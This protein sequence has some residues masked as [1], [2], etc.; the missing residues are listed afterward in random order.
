MSELAIVE[1][2]LGLSDSRRGAGKRHQQA[3]CDTAQAF[4][5]RIRSYWGVENKGH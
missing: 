2:F 5:Q 4:A 1:A 3:L